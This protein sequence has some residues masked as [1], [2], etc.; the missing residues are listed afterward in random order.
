M[1]PT[2]PPVSSAKYYSSVSYRYGRTTHSNIMAC[3]RASRRHRSGAREFQSSPEPTPWNPTDRSP[4]VP[5][6]PEMTDFP[7]L[8]LLAPARRQSEYAHRIRSP[9]HAPR[10]L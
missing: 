7:R 3:G 2:E 6:E 1:A 8:Y 10:R 4:E 9:A 5:S